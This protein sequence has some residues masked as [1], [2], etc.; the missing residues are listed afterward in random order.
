[1]IWVTTL[2]YLCT[3]KRL[4]TNTSKNEC[5]WKGQS[6]LTIWILLYY[7]LINTFQKVEP[8]GWPHH[9][10]PSVQDSKIFPP[11]LHL[12]IQECALASKDPHSQH[13]LK[14]LLFT[15][16]FPGTCHFLPEK[17][18]ENNVPIAIV[19][20]GAW[21]KYLERQRSSLAQWKFYM[22]ERKN[23]EACTRPGIHPKCEK[24][25]NESWGCGVYI[26]APQRHNQKWCILTLTA[27]L[28]LVI[29]CLN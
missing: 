29:W 6:V 16:S 25:R 15:H 28:S 3:Q 14:P 5:L 27:S 1:M 18:P 8:S 23:K 22:Q 24:M 13:V 20:A 11:P 2:I 12:L 19:T 4:I 17:M 21:S 26:K 7:Q 9:N 10:V